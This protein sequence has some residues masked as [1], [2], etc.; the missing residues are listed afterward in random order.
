[1]S[2]QLN[3]LDLF[4]GAGGLSEGFIRAGFKPIAHVEMDPAACFTLRTRM[5]YHWLK[6]QDN[7]NQYVEYLNG[8]INR[9]ELYEQVPAAV[10]KS[11]INAEISETTL[12]DIFCQIDRL[13]GG[14]KLDLIIGGP[15]CQAYSVVG[16]SRSPD[17]MKGDRRNYLY[18]FYAEFLNQYKPKYFV[19]ENVNGLLSAKDED[20]NSYLEQMCDLFRKCGL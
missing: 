6:E 1:M 14:Q 4:A 15:P 2:R 10:I 19:F 5:A 11:V 12:P 20:G 16:R 7:E 9:S 18:V 8:C 3:Y 13:L 17:R